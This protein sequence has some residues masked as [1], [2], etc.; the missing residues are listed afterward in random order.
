[1]LVMGSN[2]ADTGLVVGL[3]GPVEIGMAG[4]VMTPV[5]QPR[6][7]MLLGLLG[8]GCGSDGDC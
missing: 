1:M 6:L 2:A 7:R 3:L 5:A 8:G 4:G